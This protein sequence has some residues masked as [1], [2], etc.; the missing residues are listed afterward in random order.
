[1]AANYT[2]GTATSPI[3]LLQKIVTWLVAQGWTSDSSVSDGT[4][5]RAH[6]HKGTRYVNFRAVMNE[7]GIWG[8]GQYAVGYGLCMYTGS[9]YSGASDW[10]SQAGGPIGNGQ[11]YTVGVGMPLS[12]GPFV[13]HHFFDDGSDNIM[14]VCEKTSGVFVHLGWGTMAMIGGTGAPYFFGSTSGYYSLGAGI[15]ASAYCP[16]AVGDGVNGACGFIKLDVDTFTG[17]WV[18][19][20]TYATY[21]FLGGTGWQAQTSINGGQSTTTE[22]PRYDNLKNFATP[23]LNSQPVLLPL[24]VFV[25]RAAGGKSMLGTLPS[26]FA[27]NATNYGFSNLAVYQI[28]ATNYMIFPNFAVV[29]G[30]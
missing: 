25:D 27:S 12:A 16:M 1:M 13:T 5:W 9:G 24:H 21:A 17:K 6:L 10:N 11:T 26:M 7:V 18:N 3:D 15:T 19:I 28:G 23:A 2:T 22:F 29:K 14:I 30:S 4:G 8:G 20:F